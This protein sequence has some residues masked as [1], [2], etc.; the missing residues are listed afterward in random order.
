[1]SYDLNELEELGKF[2][3]TH[4]NIGIIFSR[5][6]SLSRYALG[7]VVSLHFLFG[8]FHVLLQRF[9]DL[10][11]YTAVLQVVSLCFGHDLHH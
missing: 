9:W 6:G 2:F 3:L 10:H 1:V 4:Q 11:S 8:R 7:E 5:Y